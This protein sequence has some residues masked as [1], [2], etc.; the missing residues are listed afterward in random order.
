[1][2]WLA[3]QI[4]EL[5]QLESVHDTSRERGDSKIQ[6]QAR[7]ILIGAVRQLVQDVATRDGVTASFAAYEGLLVDSAG[8][9]ANFDALAAM[10][11]RL[12]ST[13]N[14]AS[15]PLLLSHVHQMVV[16]GDEQKVVLFQIGDLTVGILG[17]AAVTLAERLA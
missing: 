3:E 8:G 12:I 6:S 14:E 13:A 5:H 17:P 9:S 2:H 7:V 15:D 4:E 1:M 16:I 11:Q 10:G